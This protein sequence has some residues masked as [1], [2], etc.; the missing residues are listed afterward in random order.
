RCSPSRTGK[1]TS[2]AAAPPRRSRTRRALRSSPGVGK[3]GVG[4]RSAGELRV[5]LSV[6]D[7]PDPVP[8][9]PPAFQPPPMAE[10]T[11]RPPYSLRS[12]GGF[13]ARYAERQ[14]LAPEAQVPPRSTR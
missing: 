3:E 13:M 11:R 4:K 2:P 6:E 12:P 14:S 9:A 8:A 5:L 7:V 10:A 1:P